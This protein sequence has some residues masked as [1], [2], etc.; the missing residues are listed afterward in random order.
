MF[1]TRYALHYLHA[2]GH[3]NLAIKRH[4]AALADFLSCG[5]LMRDWDMDL[6]ALVPWRSSAAEAW[7]RLGNDD[8]ARRLADEQMAR[9]GGSQPRTRGISLRVLAAA[10]E[11]TQRVPLLQEAVTLLESCGDRLTLARVLG[12]LSHAH[13]AVGE[14]SRARM[15]IH[16]AILIAE[17]CGARPLREELLPNESA[18]PGAAPVRDILATLTDAERRVVALASRGY[19]NRE[20]GDKLFVTVSTVEQHLTKVYRKLNIKHRRDLPRDLDLDAADTA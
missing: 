14:H 19:T 10:S 3:Y 1:Q 11:V 15:E 17:K 2:R 9:P 5:E 12:D 16:H 20:I 4:H 7:L 13:D 8:Q 6:P 18:P